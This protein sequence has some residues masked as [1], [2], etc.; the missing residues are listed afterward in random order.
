MSSPKGGENQMND[1]YL[2]MMISDLERTS[3]IV[4]NEC[5][6]ACRSRHG[7]CRDVEETTSWVTAG[8]QGAEFEAGDMLVNSQK[9]I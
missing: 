8:S 1:S 4:D 2:I 5:L 9:H 7:R 3:N 6:S